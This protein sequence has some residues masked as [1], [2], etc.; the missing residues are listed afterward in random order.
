M[1]RKTPLSAAAPALQKYTGRTDVPGYR[2]LYTGILDGKFPADKINNR[3]LID[4]PEIAAALGLEPAQ[5]EIA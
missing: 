3:Y 4:V 5:R 2:A 1:T